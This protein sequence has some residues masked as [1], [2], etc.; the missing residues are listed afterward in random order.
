MVEGRRLDNEPFEEKMTTYTNSW[1]PTNELFDG[2][3]G[4]IQVTVSVHD[5]GGFV[6]SRRFEVSLSR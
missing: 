5:G 4:P 1:T 3:Q 6:S 2:S